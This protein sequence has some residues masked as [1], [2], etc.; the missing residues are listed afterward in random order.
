[1]INEEEFIYNL[2]EAFSGLAI[3]QPRDRRA[4]LHTNPT[5]RKWATRDVGSIQG[6]VFHQTLGWFS[7]EGVSKY[8]TGP[9]SHL[10]EGGTESIAYTLGIRKSGRI[11]LCNDLNKATWSQ[12]YKKR[13]GDE[14]KQFLSVA[15]EG[16]FKYDGCEDEHAGEPTP[17]QM[18]SCLLLW[19]FCKRTW[20]WGDRAIYG[21]YH[22]G[23]PACPGNTLKTI[24]EAIRN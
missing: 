22:F 7:L 20:G 14:N 10:A 24:I 19:D 23:K 21:H 11:A 9:S 1:M 15:L 8:H 17:E 2:G 18:I 4:A 5:G 6:L 12:G 13:P 16:F 3:P